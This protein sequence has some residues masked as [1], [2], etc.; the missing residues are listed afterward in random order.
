MGAWRGGNLCAQVKIYLGRWCDLMDGPVGLGAWDPGMHPGSA[1]GWDL[2]LLNDMTD[3]G[4][5]ARVMLVFLVREGCQD[6]E[7]QL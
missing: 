6:P 1:V 2:W 4:V 3:F 7:E 5:L